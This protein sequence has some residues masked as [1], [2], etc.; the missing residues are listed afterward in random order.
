MQQQQQPAWS[1]LRLQ[2]PLLPWRQPRTV[3]LRLVYLA[4]QLST[5]WEG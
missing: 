4:W 1:T 3:P 5:T 2:Q